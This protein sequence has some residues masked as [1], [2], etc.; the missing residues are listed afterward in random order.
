M[1]RVFKIAA[2]VIGLIGTLVA[3]DIAA[4]GWAGLI[5][6]GVCP[7]EAPAP[8]ADDTKAAE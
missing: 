6:D 7:D 5:M 4:Q 2:G 3:C 8:K 1:S